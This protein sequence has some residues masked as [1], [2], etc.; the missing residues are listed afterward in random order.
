MRAVISF[1]SITKEIAMHVHRMT[2]RAFMAKVDVLLEGGAVAMP[3]PRRTTSRTPQPGLSGPTQ[4]LAVPK[5]LPVATRGP[6][7]AGH[8]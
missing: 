3:A 6:A 5:A 1:Q 2:V 4:T 8:G 7:V